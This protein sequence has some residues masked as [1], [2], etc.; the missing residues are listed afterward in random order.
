M[1]ALTPS[2]DSNCCHVL[3]GAIATMHALSAKVSGPSAVT[4]CYIV[5]PSTIWTI[6]SPFGWRAQA[7]SPANLPAKMAPSRYDANLAKALSRSAAGV[8]GVRPRNV[9]SLAN[10]ALNP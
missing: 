5:A 6:W 8:S 2:G 9:V 7:L 10:S 1:I 3:C 4:M